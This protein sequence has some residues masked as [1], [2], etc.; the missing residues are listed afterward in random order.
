MTAK[1]EQGGEGMDREFRVSGVNYY[2][3]NGSTI[4]LYC[5]AQEVYSISCDKP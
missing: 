4:V 1:R 5:T 2:I 3:R